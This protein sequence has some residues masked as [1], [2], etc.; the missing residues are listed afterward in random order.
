MP[1]KYNEISAA[2]S[3]MNDAAMTQDALQKLLDNQ[4]KVIA[5]AAEAANEAEEEQET[6]EERAA[7]IKAHTPVVRKYKV[8]RNEPCPC[9]SG[10]KYKNC[11]LSSGKYEE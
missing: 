2:Q 11:C 1:E 5:A 4:E 7:Y 6:E 3:I 9:G 10:K 8:G